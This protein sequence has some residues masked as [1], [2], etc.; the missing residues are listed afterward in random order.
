M[1]IVINND[2]DWGFELPKS[3][4]NLEDMY[5]GCG[6]GIRLD[7]DL[8]KAV[9]NNVDGC[10]SH[11]RIAEIPDEFTDFDIIE[12]VGAPEMLIYV[13]DGKIRYA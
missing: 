7:P 13:I 2:E 4:R 9:E 12:Y 11:L 5:D 1:K 10:A 3:L 6:W 8:I